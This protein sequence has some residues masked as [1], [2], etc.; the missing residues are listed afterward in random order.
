MS[1]L[2]FCLENSEI[3][4]IVKAHFSMCHSVELIFSEDPQ[5]IL[6]YANMFSDVAAIVSQSHINKFEAS[7]YID[8]ALSKQSLSCH[9]FSIGTFEKDLKSCE[10]QYKLE[11]FDQMVDSLKKILKID[12]DGLNNHSFIDCVSM[13]AHLFLHFKAL[14]FDIFLKVKQ[15]NESKFIKRFNASEPLDHEAISK[16]MG[17]GIDDFYLKRDWLKDFSRLLIQ[18]LE[19]R[20]NVLMPTD[21]SQIIA[22]GEVFHSLKDMVKSL[23]LKPQVQKLCEISMQNVQQRLQKDSPFKSFLRNLKTRQELNFHFTFIQLTSLLCSQYIEHT[24]WP[25][26]QKDDLTE[27]LVFSAFFCDMNLPNDEML[28]ARSEEDLL[29]FNSKEMNI[30]NS[31]A[32]KIAETVRTFAGAPQGVDKIVMQH[33]GVMNGNGFVRYPMEGTVIAAQI[34][35]YSQALSLKIL[36][37][38]GRKLREILSEFESSFKESPQIEIINKF[39]RS[40]NSDTNTTS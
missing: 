29:N 40:F 24:D 6:N 31:H 39:L 25:E 8:Q 14:P 7:I 12:E 28:V 15:G 38:N 33:H 27:K 17:R 23:G 30:L 1:H 26:K 19:M 11:E 4:D 21:G 35:F 10:Q 16:Y 36:N 34:L 13:P 2:L 32:Q 37:A 18:Q 20:L 3:R 22:E 9:F 5:E